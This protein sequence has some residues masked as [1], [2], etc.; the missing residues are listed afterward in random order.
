MLKI[1]TNQFGI[2]LYVYSN[3]N[4]DVTEEDIVNAVIK[5]LEEM[6]L[7]VSGLVTKQDV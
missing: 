6:N 1:K 4:S 7:V 3:E 2:N 5:A